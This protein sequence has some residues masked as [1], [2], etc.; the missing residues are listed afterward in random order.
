[1][2]QNFDVLCIFIIPFQEFCFLRSIEPCIVG[3]GFKKNLVE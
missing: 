1:M 2:V 3:S